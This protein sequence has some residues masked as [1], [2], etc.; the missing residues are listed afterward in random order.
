M[1]GHSTTASSTESTALK[2]VMVKEGKYHEVVH[3]TIYEIYDNGQQNGT[4]YQVW[5]MKRVLEYRTFHFSIA[6]RR[7][8]WI[9][10]ASSVYSV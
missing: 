2:K 7:G 6:T 4:F 9:C 8:L 3:K 1:L 5:M 10:G